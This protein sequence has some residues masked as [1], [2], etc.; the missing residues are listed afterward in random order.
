MP[1]SEVLVGAAIGALFGGVCAGFGA[2]VAFSKIIAIIQTKIS[3]LETSC[4]SCKQNFE[5][6]IFRL[7]S[8]RM[9]ND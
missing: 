1:N 2:Y 3:G 9:D 8:A 6:R 5:T 7:E 4:A